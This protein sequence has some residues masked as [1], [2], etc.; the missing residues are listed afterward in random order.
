MAVTYRGSLATSYIIPTLE[1]SFFV[2]EN[3]LRS[4]CTVNLLRIIIQ[5]DTIWQDSGTGKIM[6]LVKL[7]KTTGSASGGCILSDRVQWD[8]NINSPDSGII[9]R[10]SFGSPI[11]ITGS[12][13][14]ICQEF[15]ARQITGVE[16]FYSFDISLGGDIAAPI[17][18]APGEL[19]SVYWSGPNTA[20]NNMIFIQAAWEEDQ[21]DVGYTIAGDVTLSSTA[22]S[23]AKVILVTDTD[24]D[25]PDPQVEVIT[26]GAPGTWSKVLA[27]GIEASAFVQYRSGETL[28]TDEGQPYLAK[29]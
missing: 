19:L 12:L 3:T 25:L 16:Q 17:K 11:T 28:Y 8:S 27:S 29:P 9:V 23:G 13:G 6:P 21:T 7:Q 1:S 5:A 24:R 10:T 14:T 20:P 2:I 18:I 22:V 26:T 4:R 15:T